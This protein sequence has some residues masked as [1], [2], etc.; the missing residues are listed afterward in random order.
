MLEHGSD[1]IVC[2]ECVDGFYCICILFTASC[3]DDRLKRLICLVGLATLGGSTSAVS[4]SLVDVWPH[5]GEASLS[6]IHISFR[7]ACLYHMNRN[8]HIRGSTRAV[9]TILVEV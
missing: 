3:I 9:S 8:G 7:Q 5:W 6:C 4:T 1:H 2:S